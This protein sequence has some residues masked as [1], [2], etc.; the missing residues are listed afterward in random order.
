MQAVASIAERQCGRKELELRMTVEPEV[1]RMLVGDALRLQQVLVNL[2]GN[3]IKF[4]ERGAVSVLVQRASNSPLMLRFSVRDTGIGMNKEQL[5][6]LFSP[7][8]QG[9]YRLRGASA[10]PVSDWSFPGI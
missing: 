4:T 7:F 3:A 9:D 5:A 6:R 10:A 2:A 1:P 8:T